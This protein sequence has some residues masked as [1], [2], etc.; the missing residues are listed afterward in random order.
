MIQHRRGCFAAEFKVSN[1]PVKRNT[2][3][4]HP[5]AKPI[6]IVAIW[7]EEALIYANTVYEADL[8]G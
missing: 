3:H 1:D 7:Q 5:K 8:V 2:P 4:F 6:K